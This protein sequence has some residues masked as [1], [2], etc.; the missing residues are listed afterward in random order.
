[1]AVHIHDC[2]ISGSKTAIRVEGAE[3]VAS[4]LHISDVEKVAEVA[5]GGSLT[6]GDVKLSRPRHVPDCGSGASQQARAHAKRKVKF[7]A[8]PAACRDCG[9]VYGSAR[10]TIMDAKFW[11][12]A[13]VQD[14]CP[15][16]GSSNAFLAIGLLKFAEEVAS[17]L[18][19]PD[20]S[21]EMLDE[22]LARAAEIALDPTEPWQNVEPIP[23]F[24]TDPLTQPDRS[25]FYAKWTFFVTLLMFL[26]QNLI[27]PE[28]VRSLLSAGLSAVYEHF[29]AE[30]TP[31]DQAPDNKGSVGDNTP[32][33]E[34]HAKLVRPIGV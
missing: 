28:D 17:Y 23:A 3:V 4:N 12:K 16:C 30:Q 10:Y 13:N 19:A 1:M 31:V 18:L 11:A 25:E 34:P 26:Q 15:A 9:M 14:S 32:S 5:N 7:C 24:R 21:K 33:N 27:P 29:N 22:L 8:A 2:K 6:L 20:I